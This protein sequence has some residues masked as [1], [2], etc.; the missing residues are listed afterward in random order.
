MSSEEV[1]KR[2]KDTYESVCSTCHGATGSGDG[3]G[4]ASLNPKPRTFTDSEWQKSVTDE[5]IKKV[6]VYG[7]ASVGKNANMPAHPLLKGQEEVLGGLLDIVRAFGKS[8]TK[9]NN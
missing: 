3:P 4:S 1:A 7:G 8:G 5:H 2:A 6:I 9:T